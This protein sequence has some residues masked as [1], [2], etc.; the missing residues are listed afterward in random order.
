MKIVLALI[1]SLFTFN[2]FACTD[3]FNGRFIDENLASNILEIK[4]INCSLHFELSLPSEARTGRVIADNV[5]RVIWDMG[6]RKISEAVSVND[7]TLTIKIV[8]KHVFDIYYQTQTYK[9]TPQ[10][11][12]FDIEIF[13]T[14][15]SYNY[16]KHI[17][18]DRE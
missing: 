9:L 18:Y 5:D 16:K 11:L 14:K 8:D 1:I 10:G 7:D 2:V 15:H 12:A 6:G 17:N 13:N 4:V 3:N